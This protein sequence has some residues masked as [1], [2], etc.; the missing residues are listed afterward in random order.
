MHRAVENAER[1]VL[2]VDTQLVYVALL[3]PLPHNLQLKGTT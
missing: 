3:L 1:N 2:A